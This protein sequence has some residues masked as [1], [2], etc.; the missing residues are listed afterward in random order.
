[1]ETGAASCQIPVVGIVNSC[2]DIPDFALTTALKFFLRY[3]S[4]CLSNI[5]CF[6]TVL[7]RSKTLH[8]F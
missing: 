6:F 8:S 2:I 4:Q 5:K 3:I 1:M 7:I